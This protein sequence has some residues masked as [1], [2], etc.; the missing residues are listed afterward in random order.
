MTY[1]R[2]IYINQRHCQSSKRAFLLIQ[3]S[4]IHRV[5]DRRSGNVLNSSFSV[6]CWVLSVL[7]G[8]VSS[9]VR[10]NH[11][12][13]LQARR[14][15]TGNTFR[16]PRAGGALE[17]NTQLLI[18]SV[19]SK[20]LKECFSRWTAVPPTCTVFFDVTWGFPTFPRVP[21]KGF[22]LAAVSC[23]WREKRSQSWSLVKY[24]VICGCIPLWST[25]AAVGT[26][27]GLFFSYWTDLIIGHRCGESRRNV[28]QMYPI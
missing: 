25:A 24:K 12:R 28:S 10:K 9:G 27:V 4:Y 20:A 7:T 18:F 17:K 6:L 16:R 21:R 11:D 19:I 3:K 8:R 1:Y 26:V 5:I 23:G 22:E 14:R 13:G 15:K 2:N